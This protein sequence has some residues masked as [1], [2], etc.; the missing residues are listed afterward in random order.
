VGA[1]FRCGRKAPPIIVPS[2]RHGHNCGRGEL[3][4][5][6]VL[7]QVSGA[8]LARLGLLIWAVAVGF[9]FGFMVGYAVRESISRRRRAAARMAAQPERYRELDGNQTLPRLE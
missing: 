5:G 6:T 2:G 7:A 3:R 8:V 9:V 1:I 4:G